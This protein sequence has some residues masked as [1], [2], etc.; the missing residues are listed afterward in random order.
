MQTSHN[1]LVI[2]SLSFWQSERNEFVCYKGEIK[3]EIKFNCPVTGNHFRT[4]V[5][6]AEGKGYSPDE[7]IRDAI[8]NFLSGKVFIENKYY[9]KLTQ[10]VTDTKS[11]HHV[12]IQVQEPFKLLFQQLFDVSRWE[13]AKMQLPSF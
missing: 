1:V 10:C 5:V 8:Q 11:I 9:S 12:D 7:V 2:E 4:T 6:T 13:F 3:A